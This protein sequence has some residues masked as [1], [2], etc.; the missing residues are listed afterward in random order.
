MENTLKKEYFIYVRD[1]S[2]SDSEAAG[3]LGLAPPN[4]HR[5]CKE[6]GLK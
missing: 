5:M 3:K 4:Y 1:H 2:E 6:M